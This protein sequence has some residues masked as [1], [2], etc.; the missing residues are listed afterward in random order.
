MINALAF[1]F[2]LVLALAF[3]QPANDATE[4]STEISRE[5]VV[6]RRPMRDRIQPDTGRWTRDYFHSSRRR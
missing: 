5:V 3:W 1:T 6:K 4:A 2:E